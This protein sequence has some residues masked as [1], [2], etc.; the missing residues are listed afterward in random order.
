MF[1]KHDKGYLGEGGIPA[2]FGGQGLFGKQAN[3]FN[4]RLKHGG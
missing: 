2:D 1:T 4:H 3:S